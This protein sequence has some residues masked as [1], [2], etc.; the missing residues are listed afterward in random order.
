MFKYYRARAR[1]KSLFLY[2]L[3]LGKIKFKSTGRNVQISSKRQIFFGDNA[4]L[5]DNSSILVWPYPINKQFI[6][7]GHD[8]IL[9]RNAQLLSH[10]G[11]ISIGDDVFIGPNV[12]IQ[13]KGHVSIGNGVKIAANTFIASSDHDISNIN[14]G[15][16]SNEITGEIILG[17]NVW[18]GAN[19]VLTKGIK[20]GDNSVI[21][22]GSIVTKSFGENAVICGNPAKLMK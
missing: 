16:L 7:I 19:C 22:A 17:N 8:F 2:W 11:S 13:G 1:V 10:G 4:V 3:S 9:E 18:I 12:Q 15:S 14:L 20:I 21:G 5:S 6:K